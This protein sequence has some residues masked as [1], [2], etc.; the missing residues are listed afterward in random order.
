MWVFP[1]IA[2]VVAFV[3]A[4]M[5]FARAIR[6]RQHYLLAWAIALSMFGVASL[7][8]VQG[9]ANGWTS[10]GFAVYW[11]LGAVLNVPFLAG[12]EVMLLSRNRT[13]HLVVWLVLIFVVA[14]T[15]SVLRGASVDAAALV[16]RL[17]SGK[18]VF[19]DGTP[20][21]RLPQLISIPSYL[22]LLGGALWSAWTMRAR[23][24]LRDRF[25]GTMLI[26]L[27][28][29]VVAGGAAFAAAGELPGFCLTLV[30]GIVAMF[31]GFLR[32][33]RSSRVP[34]TDAS[35][36]ASTSTSDSTSRPV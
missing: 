16:E 8:V 6:S 20:A 25:V 26:A 22:I 2:A 28:A 31:V 30:A 9:V 23:P 4:G 13:V 14:Y 18:E 10:R 29:S 17:P 1:L 11:A 27:G 19:G 21:H 32:A 12:G 24:E 5:L 36:A 34:E 7:A 3:F 33:S 35:T 15:V